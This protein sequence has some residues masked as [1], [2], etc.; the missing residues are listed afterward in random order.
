MQIFPDAICLFFLEIWDLGNQ[1][2]LEIGPKTQGRKG[3]H[4]PTPPFFQDSYVSFRE[5][6]PTYLENPK[7]HIED[8]NI[9]NSPNPQLPKFLHLESSENFQWMIC[10]DRGDV[11]ALRYW[12]LWR[13]GLPRLKTWRNGRMGNGSKKLCFMETALNFLGKKKQPTT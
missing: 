10:R 2:P 8:T 13:S 11:P 9:P 5:A 3:C 6:I 12:W 7:F 1:Q 4:L